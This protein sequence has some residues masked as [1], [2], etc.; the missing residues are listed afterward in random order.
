MFWKWLSID[1]V[2]GHTQNKKKIH[3]RTV[4]VYAMI[5]LFISSK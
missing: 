4:K 3:E 1:N 2:Q 5:L